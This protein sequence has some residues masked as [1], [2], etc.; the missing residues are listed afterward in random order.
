MGRECFRMHS[1]EIH[2]NNLE[3]HC[4][5]MILHNIFG[6]TSFVDLKN[7][8]GDICNTFHQAY[9]KFHSLDNDKDWGNTIKKASLCKDSN[10]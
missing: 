2:V 3:C 7:I 6:P 5:R 1:D 9:D 4:L 10:E 8:D